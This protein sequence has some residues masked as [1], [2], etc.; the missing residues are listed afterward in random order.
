MYFGNRRLANCGQGLEHTVPDLGI[1]DLVVLVPERVANASRCLPASPGIQPVEIV[2]EFVGRFAAALQTAFHGITDF[3]VA[4]VRLEVHACDVTLDALAIVH[5][6]TQAI[7]R[8]A[9]RHA[10]LPAQ[11][12]Q[13]RSGEA[14]LG[15][16]H[17]RN[18][19]SILPELPY[20]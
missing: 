5:D 14:G 1:T 13:R 3:L 4:R 20:L 15:G 7:D 10:P 18:A 11:L 17:R 6:V 12:R 2:A 9:R 19:P 8:T 16:L